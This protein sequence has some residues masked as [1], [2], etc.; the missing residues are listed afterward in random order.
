[1]MQSCCLYC[2]ASTRGPVTLT[3]CRSLQDAS[4]CGHPEIITWSLVFNHTL[5]KLD[6]SNERNTM[7]TTTPA[8]Q[9]FFDQ[10]AQSRS[11]LDIDLIASQYL[12]SIMFAGP[13]GA[14]V[15][16]KPAILAAF[17]KGQEF[18]KAH[19]H[20]STKVLS[21][22]ET[23]LD[24]HYVLVRAQFVW[25]F[26][27]SSAQPIDVRVDSTFILYINNGSPKIVF[28]HEREDFQQALRARGVLPATQ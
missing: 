13:N 19:G 5:E 23:R 21:L 4:V 28:Q 24:D 12:D 2:G 7:K 8:V 17:P 10:Y 6:L 9:E 1:M 25:R 18:L 22:D 11:A 14:R 15:A 26:E 16:E 27:K 20:K 3:L